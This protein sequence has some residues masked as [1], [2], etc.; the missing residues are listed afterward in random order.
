VTKRYEDMYYRDYTYISM[1]K[2]TIIKIRVVD[3]I[4]ED[5]GTI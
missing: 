2:F 4:P 3:I 5:E 1:I